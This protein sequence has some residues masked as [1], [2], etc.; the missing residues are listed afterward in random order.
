MSE[1]TGILPPEL[2]DLG[3]MALADPGF[4]ERL[5]ESLRRLPRA[6]AV[7]ER[8]RSAPALDEALELAACS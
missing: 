5:V 3:L 8:P 2:A 6:A 4:A 1:F 7:D